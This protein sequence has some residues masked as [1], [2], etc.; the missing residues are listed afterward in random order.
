MK[1]D[2][3][4]DYFKLRSVTKNALEVIRFRK[5][6][7]PQAELKVCFRERPP[8]FLRGDHADFHMF[9][10]IFL[11]DEYKLEQLKDKPQV[12]LDLGGNVG[13]FAARI[14][15]ECTKLIICEPIPENIERVKKNTA[16]HDNVVLIEKAVTSSVGTLKLY[17]PKSSKA[18]G[19]FSSFADNDLLTEECLEVE[20]TSLEQIFKE[21]QLDKVDLLKI[22]IEVSE[23]EVLHASAELLPRI[24]SIHGEYHDVSPEDPRTRIDNFTKFLEDSGY[25]VLIEPH[26]K[27]PNRA[28]FYAIRD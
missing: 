11:R 9:H 18:S 7:D 12:V 8:L 3:L 19:T 1:I 10:R 28:M 5:S 23:Y 22:D 2:D 25:S 15:A 24:Q 17:L 6:R 26:S 14:A 20:T 13:L 21:Q 4:F 16:G 27:H